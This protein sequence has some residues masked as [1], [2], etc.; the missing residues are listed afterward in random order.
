M[1][2]KEFISEILEM[3]IDI[4]FTDSIERSHSEKRDIILKNIY[5]KYPDLTIS[6]GSDT[7]Y[8]AIWKSS[9]FEYSYG[10]IGEAGDNPILF[11]GT[12]EQVEKKFNK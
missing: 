2:L 9:K 6:D 4:D 10:K 1:E 8:Y 11:M 5:C 7:S 3:Y 12:R